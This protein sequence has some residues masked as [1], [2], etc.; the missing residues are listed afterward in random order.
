MKGIKVGVE[1]AIEQ[2]PDDIG[3]GSSQAFLRFHVEVLCAVLLEDAGVMLSR[4]P[5]R[6]D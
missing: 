4:S 1:A 6:N 2:I 5:L 3:I